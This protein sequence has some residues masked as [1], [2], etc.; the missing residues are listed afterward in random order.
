M[1]IEKDYEIKNAD[2]TKWYHSTEWATDGWVS[3]KMLKNVIFTLREANIIENDVN[4]A[5]LV[6]QRNRL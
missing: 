3:N 1:L 2:A 5:Q 4:I 6:W